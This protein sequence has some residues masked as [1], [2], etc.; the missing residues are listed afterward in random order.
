MEDFK[1]LEIASSSRKGL[2]WISGQIRESVIAKAD[3]GDKAEK[4]D[5]GAKPAKADLGVPKLGPCW[6]WYTRV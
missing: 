4:V 5:K 3:K 2:W 1:N 6:E